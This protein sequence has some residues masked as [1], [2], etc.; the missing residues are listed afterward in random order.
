MF[1]SQDNPQAC[2]PQ[3]GNREEKRQ[4][5][6]AHQELA[7]QIAERQRLEETLR[8][9]QI[10]LSHKTEQLEQ[11]QAELQLTKNQ[12]IHNDKIFNLGQLVACIAHD[13]NNPVNFVY[14]NLTPASKYARDLLNLL[15]LYAKNYP[16]PVLEV[17]QQALE[18]DLDFII[19]D[20]PKTLSSMHSG[21]DRIRNIVQ[22]LHHFVSHD[23]NKSFVNIHQEIDNTLLIINNRF[24]AKGDKPA[25]TLIKEYGELPLV[26]C[27]PGL[28]NQVLM[29]LL[30]NAIDALESSYQN[31][32][33]KASFANNS[34]LTVCDAVPGKKPSNL[35]Q[36]YLEPPDCLLTIF[37]EI[38]QSHD[39]NN[40]NW[41]VIRISD[42]GS[43]I[44]EE[45]KE[46]I[47]EAFFTTKPLGKGTG[48]GL[49]ISHQI[50]TENHNGRLKCFSEPGKGTDFVIE[51]PIR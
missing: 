39:E 3:Q 11:A 20:F 37:T 50:I 30:C 19:E 49:F 31:R 44:S 35:P 12:L 10:Q 42:N 18:I 16:Q 51:I 45:I 14:G 25:I 8:Q 47:F 4:L 24:K 21:A 33:V 7:A 15:K 41:A 2:P 13:I 23:V 36:L 9:C 26:E 46:R 1:L 40:G 43:G 48:L 6:H 38:R 29:N 5:R 28:L 27:Y 22:S 17:Q 32:R 34:I